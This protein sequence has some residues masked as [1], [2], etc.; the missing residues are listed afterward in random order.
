MSLTLV[1]TWEA[2]RDIRRAESCVQSPTFS[3]ANSPAAIGT[4]VDH[5]PEIDLFDVATEFFV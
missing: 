5:G 1:F 4:P 2:S 3:V